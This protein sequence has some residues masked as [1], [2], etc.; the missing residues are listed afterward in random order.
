MKFKFSDQ[1]QYIKHF[2][3][4]KVF[5]NELKGHFRPLWS[6]VAKCEIAFPRKSQYCTPN[7]SLVHLLSFHCT[8][9]WSYNNATGMKNHHSLALQ[10]EILIDAIRWCL[11]LNQL[12][13]TKTTEESWVVTD[14]WLK[15]QCP[16]PSWGVNVKFDLDEHWVEFWNFHHMVEPSYNSATEG[17]EMF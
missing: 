12:S 7:L 3:S 11:S 16:L 14:N 17:K 6:M 10:F 5:E 2:I 15:L 1:F 8:V 4:K 9:V 13:A